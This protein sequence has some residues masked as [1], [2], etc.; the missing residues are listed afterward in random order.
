M[1]IDELWED[2]VVAK[3]PV[4]ALASHYSASPVLQM[5]FLVAILRIGLAST[6]PLSIDEAYAVVVSRSHSLSY[7]DHPPLGFALARFMADIIAANAGLL[8]GFPMWCWVPC[9]RCCFSP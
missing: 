1:H 8:F 7:F 9:R 6:I 5:I 3:R 2:T 4:T